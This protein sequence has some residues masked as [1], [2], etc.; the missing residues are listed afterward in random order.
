MEAQ[1]YPDDFDGIIAGAPAFNWTGFMAE[2]IQN[3]QLN[4]PDT[5]N[6]GKPFITP[7]NLKLLESSILGACDETDGVA[8]G[9]LEDPRAC[10]FDLAAIPVCTDEQGG[11]DCFT[12]PQRSAIQQIYAPV[13]NV[14]GFIY[15]GQPFGGESHDRGV[16]N[17]DSRHRGK[18]VR[19][20]RDPKPP[21]GI[22]DRVLQIHRIR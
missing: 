10:A 18:A 16:G 19:S 6:L 21:M 11:P 1:R 3:I 8:D 22:W 14:N 17:L 2:F 13:E 9:L 7:G 12:D 5:T 15:S 20:T 4:F